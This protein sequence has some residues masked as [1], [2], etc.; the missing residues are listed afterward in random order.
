MKYVFA[1][2]IAVLALMFL[3]AP[4]TADWKPG[5]PYKMHFPQLPDEDGWD[6]NFE[7]PK[8]LAD[9]WLCT[10]SGPVSDIHWWLS[11]RYDDMP[12][13]ILFHVAIYDNIEPNVDPAMP[14][15]HPGNVQWDRDFWVSPILYAQGPQGWYDPNTEFHTDPADPDHHNIFQVNIPEIRDNPFQQEEG[16]VYWLAITAV[17]PIMEPGYPYLGWKTADTQQYPPGWEGEHFMDDAVFG[18]IDD[19]S[20]TMPTFWKELYDPITGQSLDLAFVITPEPGTWAMV[21]GAGLMGL[22]AYARRRR[23]S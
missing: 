7:S 11:A 17:E 16:K 8:V 14:W 4:A 5:D 13:E 18:D 20:G 19:A 2:L 6:V 9:D 12:T 10:Q 3:A 15:S 21:I 23:K 1:A 22:L